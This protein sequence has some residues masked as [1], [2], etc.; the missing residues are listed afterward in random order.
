MTHQNKKSASFNAKFTILLIRYSN[1]SL[2]PGPTR[3]SQ[4]A[5]STWTDFYIDYN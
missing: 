5:T 3:F 4:V 1:S 2:E